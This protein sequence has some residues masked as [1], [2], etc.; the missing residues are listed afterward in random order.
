[1]L[2]GSP[3]VKDTNRKITVKNADKNTFKEKQ[4]SFITYKQVFNFF[5]RNCILCYYR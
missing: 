2:N 5:H 1:M 3:L 4:N